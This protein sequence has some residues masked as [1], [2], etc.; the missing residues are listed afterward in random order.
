MT[1]FNILFGIHIIY[2]PLLLQELFCFYIFWVF[3]FFFFLSFFFFVFSGA[4]TNQQLLAYF[5]VNI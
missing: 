4:Q 5:D 1:S 3:L 2:S